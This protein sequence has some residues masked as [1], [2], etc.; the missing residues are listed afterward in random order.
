MAKFRFNLEAVLTQRRAKEQEKQR[1]VGELERDRLTLEGR[2]RTWNESLRAGRE[3]M[4]EAL[5]S[6]GGGPVSVGDVRLHAAASLR[7]VAEA[8]R[9]AVALAGLYRKIERAR[10]ELLDAARSRRAVELLK[11]RRYEEWKREQDKREA[12]AVDEIAVMRASRR[13]ERVA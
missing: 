3:E 7:M 1:V 8:E 4:R 11:E 12:E 10:G 9:L 5:G 2:L 13:E 6:P